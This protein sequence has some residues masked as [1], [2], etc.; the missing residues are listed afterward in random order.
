MTESESNSIVSS[1]SAR[2][3]SGLTLARNT[4]FAALIFVCG[5]NGLVPKVLDSL[6][7]SAPQPS[8]VIFLGL[9]L[10]C[11]ALLKA[12]PVQLKHTDLALG[13][14]A[15]P[16]LL[17]PQSDPS[18]FAM[19]LVAIYLLVQ[20]GNDLQLRA[21]AFIALALT[22]Q[23]LWGRLIPAYFSGPLERFDLG[24]LALLMGRQTS[25]NLMNFVHGTGGIVVAWQ[26]TSFANASLALLLWVAIM[27]TVRP[28]PKRGEW[29]NL[30]GVFASVFAINT[31]RLVIMA[32]SM[33]M[34]NLA[35]GP[36]GAFW[37]NLI[38]LLAALGW[39]AYGLRRELAN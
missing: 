26:C 25:G 19:T 22:I 5:A 27:R 31:I 1:L 30:A 32:Q 15:A 7:Y 3:I 20:R 33:S 2:R 24:A 11:W 37:A 10:A 28:V 29:L 13:V 18:W 9:A 36:L 12:Q 16:F 21:G 6:A 34:Y 35:H 23:P 4:Y 39:C 38:M 8:W 14:V 17:W